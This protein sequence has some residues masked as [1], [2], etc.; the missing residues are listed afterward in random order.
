MFK[1]QPN[2]TFKAEV[3]IPVPGGKPGKITAIFKHKGKKELQSFFES[4]QTEGDQRS[5]VDALGELLAG[6][7]GVDDKFSEENLGILLDAYPGSAMAFF[8]T[9]RKE[10]L[11]A[12]TKN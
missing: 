6:W 12:R 7:E 10:A 11:E 1:L 9:F 8:E 5:D 4:L 3:L 2:P